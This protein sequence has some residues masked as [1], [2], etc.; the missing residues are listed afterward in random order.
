MERPEKRAAVTRIAAAGHA[1]A[2]HG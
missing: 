1:L 2:N